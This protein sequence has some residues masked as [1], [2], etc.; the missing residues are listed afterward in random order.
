MQS[1]AVVDIRGERTDVRKRRRGSRA[2]MFSEAEDQ[3]CRFVA[4]PIFLFLGGRLVTHRHLDIERH[5]ILFVGVVQLVYR[6]PLD[7]GEVAGLQAPY[8]A[9]LHL[10]EIIFASDFQNVRPVGRGSSAII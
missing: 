10:D 4:E 8:G 6:D 5:D 2:K 9:V 3:Q 7:R 1:L